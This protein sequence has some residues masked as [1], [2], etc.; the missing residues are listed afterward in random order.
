MYDQALTLHRHTGNLRGEGEVLCNYAVTLHELGD[1]SQAIAEAEKSLRI[2]EDIE[3]PNASV[4]RK[5][6]EAWQGQQ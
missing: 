2:F 5:N 6:L 3:D 1:Q 4:V